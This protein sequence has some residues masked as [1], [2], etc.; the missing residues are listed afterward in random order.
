MNRLLVRRTAGQ[1]LR[2][3]AATDHRS[4]ETIQT[5]AGR[6][7]PRRDAITGLAAR[8]GGSRIDVRS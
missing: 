8:A 7:D 3:V 5:E 1:P 2:A 6:R 4:M